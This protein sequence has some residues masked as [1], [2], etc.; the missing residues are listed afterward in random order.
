MRRREGPRHRLCLFTRSIFGA[1][2]VFPLVGW[3]RS[4]HPVIYWLPGAVVFLRS[5]FRYATQ[6][7]VG[8]FTVYVGLITFP[9][10][11]PAG[12]HRLPLSNMASG[13]STQDWKN[14]IHCKTDDRKSQTYL[15]HGVR[16]LKR[17]RPSANSK[18]RLVLFHELRPL[19]GGLPARQAERRQLPTNHARICLPYFA[20]YMRFP[21]RV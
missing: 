13:L 6:H 5:S 1:C 10:Q 8:L 11:N 18:A 15:E 17:R 12:T 9:S 21:S 19:A 7:W 14:Q 4:A 3:F 16:L 2:P 20:A